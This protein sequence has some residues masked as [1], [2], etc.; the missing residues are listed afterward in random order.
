MSKKDKKYRFIGEPISSE[1]EM[2]AVDMEYMIEYGYEHFGDVISNL[3]K[4]KHLLTDCEFV[5]KQTNNLIIKFNDKN[6]I[7]S[8]DADIE[9]LNDLL[10]Y[11]DHIEN[12]HY[13]YLPQDKGFEYDSAYKSIARRIGEYNERMIEIFDYYFNLIPYVENEREVL[14]PETQRY[15]RVV[16]DNENERIY[17]QTVH[18]GF[19]NKETREL[20]K[21]EAVVVINDPLKMINPS[22]RFERQR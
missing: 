15:Y 18:V 13:K 6:F 11:Y 17:T 14:F 21:K 19:I 1:L 16:T 8:K 20:A 5:L 2:I 12:L 9:L 4:F 3:Q 7:N 10:S 22:T